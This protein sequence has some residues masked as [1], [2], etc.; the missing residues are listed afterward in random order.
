MR[1]KLNWIDRV[2]GYVSPQAGVKRARAR[3]VGEFFET[4][5]QRKYEAASH[6]RRTDGWITP[7]TNADA[8]I[9]AALPKLRDRSRDLVRNNPIAARAIAVIA[10]NTVGTGIMAKHRT[11]SREA[12][13]RADGL[14]KSWAEKTS[15][16][17][18]GRHDFFGLQNL[19]M[20]TVA[21]AGECLVRRVP[22][23]ASDGLS[24]PL[25]IQV[26]EPD[27]LDTAQERK[28][29][30]GGQIV[31][32]IEY[33]AMGAVAAYYL[34]PHHPGGSNS[35][36]P[37]IRIPASEVKHV[38]RG[39]RPGQ[40]R[41]VPWSAPVMIRIKD[42]DEFM[43]AQLLKLKTSCAFTAFVYDS[44][45]P[46]DASVAS[47]ALGERLE[48]GMIE[49]LPPG[50]DIKFATPP[51]ADGSSE[52][53]VETLRA[54]AGAYG[55]SYESLTNDYSR[56]NY[57]SG[58]MG[59]IEMS[60]NI[61]QWRWQVLIPQFCQPVWDWFAEAAG[62]AGTALDGLR[63]EW[64]AP[65][66]EM[67]DPTREIP[68]LIHAARGGLMS[69]SEIHRQSGYDSDSVLEEIA[70]DNEKIDALGLIFDSDARKTAKTGGA[71]SYIG[72]PD[73]KAAEPTPEP[74]PTP[75]A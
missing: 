26:L 49:I 63:V 66:R 73:G 56:V 20:R 10:S 41:G 72:S 62:I 64:S 71:Q 50:K 25:R 37:S 17:V 35:V 15:I 22:A 34:F 2:V 18:A 19:V 44:E 59:W 48:P 27:F 51:G 21:E 9:K 38:F 32:G 75:T 30:G 6:G 68:A 36:G 7:S 55:I 3:L 54:I 61:D 12:E 53:V 70:R 31:A 45:A 67:I 24:V 23:K 57:S 29:P 13:I 58:R 28:L 74:L 43:D 4:N 5:L 11:E 33:D 46:I 69:L 8:E 1:S 40:G 14:W 47:A 42:L 16:D 65:R 52:F 39:D 60:R